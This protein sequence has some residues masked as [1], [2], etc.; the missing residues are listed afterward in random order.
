MG[1]VASLFF[2][3][4]ARQGDLSTSPLISSAEKKHSCYNSIRGLS[5]LKFLGVKQ[6]IK[7]Y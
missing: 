4:A 1:M 5:G 3:F 7:V 6:D 2:L